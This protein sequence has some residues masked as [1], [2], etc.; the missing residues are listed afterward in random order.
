MT[1][2]KKVSLKKLKQLYDEAL[3][4]EKQE[5]ILVV[6]DEKFE[7]LTTYLKY[8]IEYL[9]SEYKRRGWPDTY[10]CPIQQRIFNK[11]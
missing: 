3:K 1:E 5:I 2:E 8:L 11:E 7:L 10:E 4:D 9:E 6:Q